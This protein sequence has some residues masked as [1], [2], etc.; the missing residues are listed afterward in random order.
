MICWIKLEFEDTEGDHNVSSDDSSD[1]ASNNV[2]GSMKSFNNRDQSTSNEEFMK[3]AKAGHVNKIKAT[4][5]P[6]VAMPTR[7]RLQPQTKSKSK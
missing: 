7:K 4:P 3:I 1:P 6:P 2:N 5:P